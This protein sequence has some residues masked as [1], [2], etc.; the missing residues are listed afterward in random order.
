MFPFGC[1]G[2]RDPWMGRDRA[3][4]LDYPFLADLLPLANPPGVFP[5]ENPR[6]PEW[7]ERVS[8][9][10]CPRRGVRACFLGHAPRGDER[11]S[12]L[13]ATPF[14]GFGTRFWLVQG[15]GREDGSFI[16][17]EPSAAIAF[18]TP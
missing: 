1:G 15:K 2:F 8:G 12:G 10:A 11:I 4:R 6:S 17:G 5:G 7:F 16:G 13:T 14:S 18:T 3:A 9:E